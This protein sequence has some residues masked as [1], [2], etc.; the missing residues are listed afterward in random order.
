MKRMRNDRGFSVLELAM[1]L[2]I[3]AILARLSVPLLSEY[4]VRARAAKAA[5]D[6]NTVRA[7]AFAY[8]ESNGR[9][10]DEVG[11]G[12]IPPGLAEF[13]P[14][15]FTFD[16]RDYQLDWESWEITHGDDGQGMI[17]VLV[18]VSVVTEDRDLGNSI[19]KILGANTVEWTAGDHY[20]FVIQSTLSSAAPG[21]RT[22]ET[23]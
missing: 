23:R 16:R 8:F 2:A 9:W 11:P 1:A 6:F 12:T 5:A 18:G 14:R 22:T 10:P 19:L 13:L 21:A 4:L 20:T 3:V 7:G 15:N 17:G